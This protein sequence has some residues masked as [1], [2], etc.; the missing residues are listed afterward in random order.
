[1][2]KRI[3][4]AA[5]QQK[6]ATLVYVGPT[7][8]KLGISQF[9]LYRDGIPLH[10]NAAVKECSY[11]SELFVPVESLNAARRDINRDGSRLRTVY[12]NVSSF[13]NNR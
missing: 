2:A 11:L 8:S 12:L 6:P 3:R 5:E 10:L 13:F 4:Q 1:M 7:I 9:S